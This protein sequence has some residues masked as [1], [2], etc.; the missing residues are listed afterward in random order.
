MS[1]ARTR[2]Y[3]AGRVPTTPVGITIGESTPTAAGRVALLA[4]ANAVAR[5]HPTVYVNA[6]NVE[7]DDGVSIHDTLAGI[8]GA[9]ETSKLEIVDTMPEGVTTIGI[10][11]DVMADL[12]V[13]AERFTG[14]AAARRVPISEDSSSRY[15]AGIGAMLAAAIVF[16]RDVGL[17]VPEFPAL[18]LWTFDASD[19]ATGPADVGAIDIGSGWVVGAGGVGSSLAWWLHVLGNTSPWTFIDHDMVDATNLN[20][21]LG[22][23]ARHLDRGDGTPWAKADVAADLVEGATAFDGTWDDWMATDP[24]ASELIVPAANEFGVRG[25]LASYGH[26][27]ALTGTTSLD[28]TAELHVYRSGVDGC[29]DCRHPNTNSPAFPCSTVTIPTATDASVDAALAF[30]SGTA[31]LMTVAAVARLQAGDSFDILNHWTVAFRPS[32]RTIEG[33]R[34]ECNGGTAHGPDPR[35]RASQFGHTRWAS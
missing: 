2:Q 21:S 23:F 24:P 27:I 12:Y 29:I 8:G 32:R 18:S 20:R 13:G 6:P 15:G 30:L 1:D 28:W 22:M 4:A 16:R 35:V 9:T 19:E 34:Y 5:S 11:T 25:S 26:P 10:G 14:R 31:A 3:T 17:P 33:D 7:G